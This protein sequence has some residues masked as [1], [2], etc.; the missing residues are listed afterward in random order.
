MSPRRASGFCAVGSAGWEGRG[1]SAPA[2]PT[3]PVSELG[4]APPR[5][6]GLTRAPAPPVGSPASRHSH[7]TVGFCTQE[8]TGQAGNC[9]PTFLLECP[10]RRCASSRGAPA[11]LPTPP[12]WAQAETVRA[13][14]RGPLLSGVPSCTPSGAIHSCPPSQSSP[15]TSAFPGLAGMWALTGSGVRGLSGR[16]KGS[17]RQPCQWLAGRNS[18]SGHREGEPQDEDASGLIGGVRPPRM[19]GEDAL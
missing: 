7:P 13:A 5:K 15:H 4:T 18:N 12:G 3:L 14:A 16:A 10:N 9:L 2:P 11:V 19:C 6:T 17:P 1:L 8:S